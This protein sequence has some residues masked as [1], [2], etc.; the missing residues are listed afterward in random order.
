MFLPFLQEPDSRRSLYA[1]VLNAAS[2]ESSRVDR[3]EWRMNSLLA[4]ILW[5]E[6][7]TVDHWYAGVVCTLETQTEVTE[8]EKESFDK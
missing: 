3:Q 5:T 8:L 6:V 1:V 4:A 2:G 7:H